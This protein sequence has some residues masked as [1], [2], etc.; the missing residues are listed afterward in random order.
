VSELRD[1]SYRVALA[2]ALQAQ[3]EGLAE[4]ASREELEACIS[5]ENV[6]ANVSIASAH[7]Q[8][9]L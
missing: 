1:V 4:Q 9:G 8:L 3:R 2:V 7:V 6:D 5:A